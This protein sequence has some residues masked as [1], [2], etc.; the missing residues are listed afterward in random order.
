MR[1]IFQ[2]L[3][4][5][6]LLA[7]TTKPDFMSAVFGTWTTDF[8]RSWDGAGV[9]TALID[10]EALRAAWQ[11]P[12][13]PAGTSLLVQQAWLSKVPGS[14]RRPGEDTAHPIWT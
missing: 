2:G 8:V 5:D 13:P 6:E 9:D 1:S 10:I 4:P 3:L 7:R 12:A 14:P 11:K